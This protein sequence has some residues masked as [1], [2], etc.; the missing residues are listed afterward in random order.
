MAMFSHYHNKQNIGNALL[1]PTIVSRAYT[2]GSFLKKPFRYSDCLVING[3]TLYS[4][5]SFYDDWKTYKSFIYPPA[6]SPDHV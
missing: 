1:I 4:P 5:F 2:T 6:E 3:F